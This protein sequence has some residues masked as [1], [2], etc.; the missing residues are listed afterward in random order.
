MNKIRLFPGD[1]AII[2]GAW[3]TADRTVTLTS[4]AQIER[5]PTPGLTDLPETDLR[6]ECLWSRQGRRAPM[7]LRHD[8]RC[9]CGSVYV[10]QSETHYSCQG[11]RRVW[12]NDE[13]PGD[14]AASQRGSQGR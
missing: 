14:D 10:R 4:D 1:A 3:V 11:C 8:L 7:T 6:I 2:N 13:V 12:G 5:V 9:P